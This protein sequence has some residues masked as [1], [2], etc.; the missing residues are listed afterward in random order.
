MEP[1]WISSRSSTEVGIKKGIT[2]GIPKER[3]PCDEQWALQE[4]PVKKENPEHGLGKGKVST[5]FVD[6]S[7][8]FHR[9]NHKSR[10]IFIQNL[11]LGLIVAGIAFA[12]GA[13]DL[14]ESMIPGTL[15]FAVGVIGGFKGG[16]IK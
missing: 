5:T 10:K 4:L 12:G 14:G 11:S 6:N 13:F 15:F 7:S 8:T 9:K 3:G 16:L 2:M 1:F